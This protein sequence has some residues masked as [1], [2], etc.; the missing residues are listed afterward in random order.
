MNYVGK[1]GILVHLSS[2][3][4]EFDGCVGLFGNEIFYYINNIDTIFAFIERKNT[5]TQHEPKF[6]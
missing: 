5:F 2:E 4:I 3:D 6:G 1:T